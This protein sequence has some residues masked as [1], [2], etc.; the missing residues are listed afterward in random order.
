[1][2]KKYQ[3]WRDMHTIAGEQRQRQKG[4]NS[5]IIKVAYGV[6]LHFKHFYV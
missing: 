4:E 2:K 6:K 3:I 1:M 5:G